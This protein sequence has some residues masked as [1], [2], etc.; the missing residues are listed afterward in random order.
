MGCFCCTIRVKNIKLL[1]DRRKRYRVKC[2]ELN[3]TLYYNRGFFSTIFK[4]TKIEEELLLLRKKKKHQ[5]LKDT[6]AP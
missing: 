4:F 5:R 6:R 3:Q 2:I 1:Q